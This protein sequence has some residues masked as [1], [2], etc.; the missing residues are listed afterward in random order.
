MRELR[1]KPYSTDD[2]FKE[3]VKMAL[4]E[5]PDVKRIV[6]YTLPDEDEMEPK[7]SKSTK[8]PHKN[9]H[10]E[11]TKMLTIS[12][13]H[14]S[15]ET[16]KKLDATCDDAMAADHWM[17]PIYEK[18][19]F[20][21]F[22]FIDTDV[23]K[24]YENIPADLKTVLTYAANCGCTWL[25]LDAD[26]DQI[27][28]LPTYPRGCEDVMEAKLLPRYTWNHNSDGSGSLKS[29]DGSQVL[30]YDLTT[31]E[32]KMLIG[33]HLGWNLIPNGYLLEKFKEFAEK[34]CLDIL[35]SN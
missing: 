8:T 29:P 19:G 11:F 26:A 1:K 12:T 28:E 31:G 9:P 32:Y 14:V 22:I 25:C 3:V 34:K 27:P 10:G 13:L 21:W 30:E 7:L 15:E 16:A 17:P 35:K 18:D 2:F 6:D 20:G 23:M 5:H 24:E 33:Q 4:N